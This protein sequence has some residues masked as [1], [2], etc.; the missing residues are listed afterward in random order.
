MT[1]NW[2]SEFLEMLLFATLTAILFQKGS[3][4]SKKLDGEPEDEEASARRKDAPWPV[5]KGGWIREIYAYSLSLT[6]LAL[7][8]LTF[9]LHAVSGARRENEENRMQG[10]PER[11]T[12]IEFLSSSK[13]W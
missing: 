10:K 8:V 3:A 6:F 13:F 9:I 5:R 11:V 1:E 4:E 2:E 7:L 12:T